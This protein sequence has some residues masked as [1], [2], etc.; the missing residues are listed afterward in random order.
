MNELTNSQKADVFFK[1]ATEELDLEYG[2]MENWKIAEQLRPVA[3]SSGSSP[4]ICDAVRHTIYAIYRSYTMLDI[5]QDEMKAFGM[6][7]TGLNV[8]NHIPAEER[9]EA[10]WFF[11]MLMVEY[12]DDADS[13]TE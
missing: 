1:A 7:H 12:L 8:W 10:R 2:N 4:Y 3:Q 5:F 9:Q 6:S 11:L 13:K